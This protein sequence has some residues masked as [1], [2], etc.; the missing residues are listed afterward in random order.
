MSS[1]AKMV[2]AAGALMLGVASLASPAASED[3]QAGFASWQ[4]VPTQELDGMR[5]MADPTEINLEAFF[6]AE[7][8][9]NDFS[10]AII[11]DPNALPAT[12][13]NDIS[14]S[15]N[16]SSG[17]VMVVQNTGSGVII[18]SATLVSVNFIPGD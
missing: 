16:N 5:G 7:L 14:G 15:F 8:N 1:M 13:L 2:A 17:I 9:N 6:H 10:G 4:A 3:A 12:P 11:I 18:Q